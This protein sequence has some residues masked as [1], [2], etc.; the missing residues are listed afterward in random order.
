MHH[1]REFHVRLRSLSASDGHSWVPHCQRWAQLGPSVPTMGTAGCLSANDGHSWVPQCQRW[2]QLG[3]SVPAMGTAGSLS[4]SDG[5]SWVPQCQRWDSW[6]PHVERTH[7][8]PLNSPS[9]DSSTKPL[10]HALHILP[11]SRPNPGHATQGLGP[12]ACA[13][14]FT[15]LA[16]ARPWESPGQSSPVAAVPLWHVHT[17]L[18]SA[19]AVFK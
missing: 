10:S 5:H 18:Q 14:V 16:M 13:L 15:L 9:W 2:A 6:V 8:F 4:A 11:W 19:V 3:A 17:S 12:V 7:F 1:Q